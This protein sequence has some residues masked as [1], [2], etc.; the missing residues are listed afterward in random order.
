M[1]WIGDPT[2]NG[3][4]AYVEAQAE[5]IRAGELSL[6]ERWD[7]LREEEAELHILTGG[8]P[9]DIKNAQSDDENSI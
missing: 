4:Q 9:D 2:R 6:Q 8:L 1:T 7:K 3:Y 5:K